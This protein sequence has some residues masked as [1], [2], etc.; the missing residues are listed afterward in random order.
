MK[1]RI[2][3]GRLMSGHNGPK[4][5]LGFQWKGVQAMEI[6]VQSSQGLIVEASFGGFKVATDQPFAD[7]GSNSAPSPFDLFLASL[8]TCSGHYVAAFCRKRDLPVED[9]VLKMTN[10][11]NDR[12]HLAEN[13]HIEVILPADFPAKY[14][15]AVT[16]AAGMC[17]VKRHLENPPAFTIRA[18]NGHLE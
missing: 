16:R 18:R 11:W 17:T 8:A 14:R 15:R 2:P 13:I 12:T 6:H 4:N 10:D 7:G 5:R 3:G 1:T 9:I